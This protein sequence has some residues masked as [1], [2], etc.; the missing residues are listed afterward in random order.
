[1][2]AFRSVRDIVWFVYGGYKGKSR[3]WKR[4]RSKRA[5][6]VIEQMGIK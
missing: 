2:K 1:M 4:R 6:R 3:K 5:I